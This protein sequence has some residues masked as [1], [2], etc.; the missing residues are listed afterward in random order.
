MRLGFRS[1]QAKLLWGT[2]LVIALVMA[3]VIVV[4]ERR[5]RDTIIEEFER[6]G[7]VLARNLAAISYGPLLLYNFTALEQNVARAA[8]EVDVVY[9]IVLDGEGKVAAHSRRPERVGSYPDGLEHERAAKTDVP[10]TQHARAPGSGEALY[11]FAVPVLVASQ[12]WGTVRVGLSKRRMEAEIRRTRFELAALALA[13]LLVGGVAAALVARRIAGPVHQ[14]EERAAA[15]ARGELNQRIEPATS[16]EIGRLAIAFNH[17]AAQLFQQRA[18]LEEVHGELKRRF[19]ELADLKSYMESII[20]SL[21]NGIV[22]V[23]L[24]GRVVTLNPAAELLTGFF[25]GEA[26]GR[27]CTEVFSHTPEL[28]EILMET[29]TSHAP[30]TN[31]AQTLKRRTGASLP[32]ELSTAPLKGSDGKDLGAVVIFR[33]LTLM[34]QLESRLR[35]SD[36]LAALG[37]LAAGLAHEIKTPLTSALTF[38]RHLTRRFEDERFRERFQ[39]VV[40]RELERI[41]EIVE[42]LLELA[43]PP[44][45]TF[46]LV[47][48]PSLLDRV[49]DLHANQIESR[50]ITVLREYA[51]DVAP[52]QADEDALYRALVNVVTNAL[53]AMGTGGRLLLRLGWDDGGNVRP[54]WRRAFNR[55]V[56]IELEDT[57]SGIAPAEADRVFNP[58]FT[59]KEG[60]TGLGLALTHKIVEDHGGSIDFRSVRGVGTTFRIVLPLVPEPPG[61]PPRDDD[62]P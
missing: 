43:R 53:E 51:R 5:Q 56:K 42:R 52:I 26:A 4:V 31:V 3:A 21:T 30:I 32:I 54:S 47:R 23:D 7:E 14:L 17:M 11:D 50:Q 18:A 38:S 12:K 59:T 9:A 55:G 29:L 60:G 44:R 34:R 57:G 36:R 10:L 41:N 8:A 25:A 28:G 13:T 46:A 39:S 33:D 62:R 45:L 35:R 61:G 37:T 24:G 48:L 16:D 49:V 22:T 58:F 2:V 40:P 1:L 20:N 6:R 27:Y 19:E 15:I